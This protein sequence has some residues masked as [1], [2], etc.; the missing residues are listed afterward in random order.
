M[1][2]GKGL[3]D[4]RPQ[5]IQWSLDKRPYMI[6]DSQCARHFVRNELRIISLTPRH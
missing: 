6:T 4:F 1:K 5:G 3:L 2:I